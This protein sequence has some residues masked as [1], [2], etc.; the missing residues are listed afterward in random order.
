MLNRNLMAPGVLGLRFHF[1]IPAPED[2]G[3]LRPGCFMMTP[4]CAFLSLGSPE[5]QLSW[6]G[7]KYHTFLSFG[8]HC[9]KRPGLSHCLPI[10]RLHGSATEMHVPVLWKA[11]RTHLFS[12]KD[13]H[14]GS[15]WGEDD[16]WV[17]SVLIQVV[18]TLILSRA[19][20][21]P[22]SR[23]GNGTSASMREI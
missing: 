17:V 1:L 19:F 22:Q 11:K 13:P 23:H 10:L 7:K 5:V 18:S 14:I 9:E 8:F 12:C 4:V 2:H 16:E 21:I 6:V 15:P 20:I 3:F